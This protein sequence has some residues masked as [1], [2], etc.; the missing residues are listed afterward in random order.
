MGGALT[1]RRSL[2]VY[3]Y[4][5]TFIGCVGMSQTCQQETHAPQQTLSLFDHLVGLNKERRRYRHAEGF[6]RLQIDHELEPGGLND[7]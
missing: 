6:R 3:P 5:Q 4:Q 2:P 7:R 1:A